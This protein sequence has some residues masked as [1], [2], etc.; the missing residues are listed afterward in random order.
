[1]ETREHRSELGQWQT[2][3]R[4]ADPR[5]RAYV[6]GYFASSSNLRTPVQERHVPWIEVPLLLNLGAPHRRL[7]AVGSGEWTARDGVWVVGLHNRH[8]LTEAAG[9]RHF[10]VVRFTPMGAHLFLGLPMHLIANEAVD[11]EVIDPALA[12]VLVRRIGAA[13]SWTD[14]FAAMDSLIAERVAAAGIPASIG[15]AWR[16]L[17]AT[18]GRIALDSLVSEMDCSHRTLI[19]RFRTCVGFPPKTIA[20]LLRFNRAVRSLD[21]LSGTRADEPAS[22]PYIET[23]QPEDP[24]VGAIQWAGLAADCGYFDQAHLIKDFREF[25][26]MTPDAFLRRVSF[27]N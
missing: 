10:M 16:R 12:R 18:D 25:S 7:D 20:R 24:R 26:G 17:V 23:K 21:R 1:M 11:L 5:L 8:Q 14:R 3:Q 6:H 27:L 19:A 22:K 4:P 15:F 2:A 9:E 13:G